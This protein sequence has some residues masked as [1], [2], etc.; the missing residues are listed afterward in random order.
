MRHWKLIAGIAALVIVVGAG[1]AVL[2]LGNSLGETAAGDVR[3]GP[4]GEGAARLDMRD[5]VFDPVSIE[6]RTGE[7]VAI[8]LHNLGQANHNFTSEALRVSTGPMQPGQVKTVTV[9]IPA[10]TNQFVCT[11]HPGMV[12]QVIGT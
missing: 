4:A 2:V 3:D 8:E 5:D 9:A 1:A 7:P 6:V 12:A 11:W 10:G